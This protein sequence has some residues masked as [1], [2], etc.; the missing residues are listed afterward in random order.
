MSLLTWCLVAAL[1]VPYLPLVF[2]APAKAQLPGGYD[3]NAPRDQTAQLTGMARRAA[4]AHQNSF[5]VLPPFLFAGLLVLHFGADSLTAGY[6]GVGW[7][8]LRLAYVA[9]Y[10]GNIGALRS[11]LWMASYGC[12]AALIYLAATH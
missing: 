2:S 8:V 9:A 5:E 1:A 3:N 4:A 7:I 11:A 6:I 12:T 10:L